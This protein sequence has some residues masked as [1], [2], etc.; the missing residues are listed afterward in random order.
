[1][2][3]AAGHPLQALVSH[4]RV[5]RTTSR[6][7][8]AA[9]TKRAWPS[10]R[11]R[12]MHARFSCPHAH[13]G[14]RAHRSSTAFRP[15]AAVH[16]ADAVR[17]PAT[18]IEARKQM[19]CSLAWS[20]TTTTP[21]KNLTPD[22]PP[23]PDRHPPREHERARQPTIGMPARQRCLLSWDS[24]QRHHRLPFRTTPGLRVAN[25]SVVQRRRGAASAA[26][27]C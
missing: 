10:M 22:N 18:D 20:G 25:G 23:R 2:A 6:T 9:P 7:S 3:R 4:R 11:R 16:E 24:T 21:R 14:P 13:G 19:F 17:P 12:A 5:D 15:Q 1:M 8:R 27:A 26:S